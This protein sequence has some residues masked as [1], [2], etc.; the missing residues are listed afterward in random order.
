MKKIYILSFLTFLI[1]IVTGCKK[2]F[3]DVQPTRFLTEQQV[4]EAAEHNPDVVA[5]S[6]AG[7]YTLMFQTGTGGTNL[8]HDDF[9]QKGY[10]IYSDF[11][12]GDL[13]LHVSTYGWYRRLTEFTVTT[14]FTNNGNYKP[15]RYYYRLV[16]SANSVISAL[17]GNEA[18]PELD[19]NKHIM[20]QAKA[21]RAYCYFYLTQFYATEYIPTDEILPIYTDPLQQNQ[22]K[23]STTDVYALIVQDLTEAIPLLETFSRTGKHQI[24]KYVAEGLLAYT[25][26]VMGGND[27]LTKAKNLTADIINNGGF[28]LMSADEVAYTFTDDPVGGFND[29][30]TPGW[31]WG[32]DLTSD[33]GLDLVS[34]WGQMDRYTYSYQWAGDVKT[35][36]EGLY[37]LIPADDV[38]KKQFYADP[39]STYYLAPLYKFYDPGR[40]I[41]GQ[42]N[43]ITDY[44]YMRVA[45]MYLLNA[46]TAA[47]SDDL[48]TAKTSLKALVSIRVPDASY[49]DGL[50]KQALLDEIYLQTRIEL[51]AE[52]KSYLAMKRNHATIVR[53]ANHLSFVGESIL[54]N[55][56]RLTFS[57]PQSEIQN[58]PFIN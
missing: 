37:N 26:A 13:A 14:D 28:T 16:R 51:F 49:I 47:K 10:D 30:N 46:E 57:I 40:T 23:S 35:L 12:S 1:F 4:A 43:V 3:L 39:A 56:P 2:D 31:M 33:N 48:P 44:V 15:W 8:D 36:D 55:D 54:S 58:N 21:M 34:W 32:V 42:R 9:G 25:Y 45:E 38:R 17:G 52:G 5:G 53:G 50:S 7:I 19:E 6:M 11:L 27:N 29:I 24:N 22:P 20:G 18:V 41:G